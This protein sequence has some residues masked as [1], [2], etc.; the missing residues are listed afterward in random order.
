[1][2]FGQ[3]LSTEEQVLSL[4]ARFELEAEYSS[5]IVGDWKHD[6]G[7]SHVAMDLISGVYGD[8]L[9]RY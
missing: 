8:G 1:M 7:G 6:D 2:S 3:S 5:C 9:K 4:A